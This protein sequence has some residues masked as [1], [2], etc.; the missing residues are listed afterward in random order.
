MR[1]I[2]IGLKLLTLIRILILAVAN[3]AI[4]AS[5]YFLSDHSD[6]QR[7]VAMDEAALAGQQIWRQ[8]GC[9]SCHSLF[10]LGG[11]AG[12]DLTNVI[13]RRGPD[14]TGNVVMFG[15]GIMSAQDM[16]EEEL[17]AL[18]AYLGHVDAQGVYPVRSFPDGG[19]G[20]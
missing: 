18:M 3:V 2:V 10:G 9:A 7:R 6:P 14:Y 15:L 19:F 4:G 11:L 16:S 8:R 17:S 5:V 1:H 20:Q 12:P 13:T